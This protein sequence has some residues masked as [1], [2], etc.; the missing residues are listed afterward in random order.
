MYYAG[1]PLNNKNG[2]KNLFKQLTLSECQELC[3]IT[4]NCFYF[5]H[6]DD[7]CSLKYGMGK[8]CS[9]TENEDGRMTDTCHGITSKRKVF[10]GHKYSSGKQVL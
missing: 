4:E 2:G 8:K 7:E 9:V 3:Q 6:V 10:F 5:N 1:H